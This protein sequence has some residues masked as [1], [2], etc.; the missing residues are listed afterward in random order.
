ME[1]IEE[2]KKSLSSLEDDIHNLNVDNVSYTD[3][4]D[5]YIIQIEKLEIEN[6]NLQDEVDSLT[7]DKNSLRKE[8]DGLEDD[9]YDLRDDVEHLEEDIIGLENRKAEI[10][11]VEEYFDIESLY[12]GMKL[13][14]ILRIFKNNSLKGLQKII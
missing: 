3:Q 2:L 8:V 7:D 6:E 11:T 14:E 9:I 13:E 1:N 4:I 10:G 12:D 5:D